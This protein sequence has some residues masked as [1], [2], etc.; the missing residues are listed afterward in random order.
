MRIAPIFLALV[1]ALS[2]MVTGLPSISSV[3]TT[4]G[5]AMAQSGR[6]PRGYARLVVITDFDDMSIEVNGTAYPY[7]RIDDVQH[8][9]LLPGGRWYE[10]VVASSPE[11]RRTF[12]HKLEEGETRILMVDVRAAPPGA[13][14]SA[15]A[16][17]SPTPE[18]EDD[19]DDD[20][21]VDAPG[22][23]GVSSSP[24]GMVIVDGVNTNERTPARRLE[25]EPGR[26]EV[27][28]QYES[29][30]EISEPKYVL[31]RPGVATNVF[32]REPR[33]NR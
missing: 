18:M 10:I 7:E 20:D 22:Y 14:R 11:H 32:F 30:G 23:L 5:S 3:G 6:P 33:A 27:R 19:D 13:Q 17:R 21:D 15:P 28:V 8:G 1:I 24:R 31:I 29:S 2:L 12:R 25:T 26:R 4:D 16:S 9:L